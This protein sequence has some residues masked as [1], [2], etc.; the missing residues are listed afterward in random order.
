MNAD[1]PR[2]VTPLGMKRNA[3]FRRRRVPRPGR[4]CWRWSS[5]VQNNASAIFCNRI[6]MSTDTAL[7]K[8]PAS[9]EEVG[10]DWYVLRKPFEDAT[11]NSFAEIFDGGGKFA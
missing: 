2:L 11:F 10:V 9:L 5:I 6:D 7:G 3:S 8:S 4:S 1:T